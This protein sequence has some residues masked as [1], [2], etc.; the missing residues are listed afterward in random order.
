VQTIQ[1]AQR[2]LQSGATNARSLT[3]RCLAA[4]KSEGGEGLRTFLRLNEATA[5]ARADEIDALRRR[6]AEL[7]PYAGIRISIKD[8]F[9]AQGEVT[10]AGS[11]VLK[12]AA[13]AKTDAPAVTRLRAAG[14]I[15]IGRTNM[16]EFAYSGVGLNPHY[17]TPKNPYER[18]RGRIPG[19]SSSGAA[20]SVADGMAFAGLGTDTGG[21][22]RIPAALTGLVGWKSTAARVPREGVLPLSPT[23]DSIGWL[24][25]S[26]SCCAI[27]D[28]VVAG[29]KPA[30]SLKRASL[31]SF[32][33]AVPQTL[34]FEDIEP[35]VATAFEHALKR[36]SEAGA[37]INPI[38]F[39]ELHELSE[40]N[41]K[42]GFAAAES[43][44]WH[45]RLIETHGEQ[46]DPR[47][48]VRILRGA[49]QTTAD[50]TEL[51]QARRRLIDDV[52]SWIYD[53][54]AILLPTTPIIA[55]TFDEVATD[56]D[57]T[58]LNLLL[59]RNPSIA[60]FLDL[61]AV[62]LPCHEPDKA[63][64]GLMMITARGHDEHLLTVATEAERALTPGST[65]KFPG[66][67]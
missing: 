6:S 37:T 23:L 24:T 55:P 47:V 65:G 56:H 58:R 59:L 67:A 32:R 29:N 62:S 40:I 5:L 60:N 50:Y 2:A 63:P 21:S 12:S 54:D 4:A 39:K 31:R 7:P 42:G 38:A 51:V 26:V 49:A 3:E 15:I 20:I 17:G 13:P 22:C 52:S 41:S 8:L 61:C 28:A 43:Y 45:R 25:R 34:V 44:A 27:L 35:T 19:G 16:T 30:V 57:Y 9:D 36:L 33:F 1:E 64:V 48:R 66:P 18:S 46:Y 10:T 53:F 14:F 11:V